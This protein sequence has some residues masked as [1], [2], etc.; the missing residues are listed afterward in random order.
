MGAREAKHR[1]P[2]GSQRIDEGVAVGEAGRHA[3]PTLQHRSPDELIYERV[4]VYQR[5]RDDG[6]A[7]ILQRLFVVDDV[8]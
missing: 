3:D 2:G 6:L 4:R 7:D 5:K 8:R 1:V